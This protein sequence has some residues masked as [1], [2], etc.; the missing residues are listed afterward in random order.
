VDGVYLGSV[1]GDWLPREFV[2]EGNFQVNGQ[3]HS[4][5]IKDW[6][7]RGDPEFKRDELEALAMM[8]AM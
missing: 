5:K 6:V 7:C 4:Y 8:A 2:Y 3:S 1:K